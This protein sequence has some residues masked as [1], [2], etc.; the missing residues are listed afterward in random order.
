MPKRTNPFQNLT[1]SIMALFYEPYFN[2]EES[3]LVK[4]EETGSVRELDIL[5]THKEDSAFNILIECRDHQR[6]QDVTWIDQLQGK[7]ARLGYLNIVAVSSSGFTEPAIL[8][9][10]ARGIETLHLREAETEDW[11][12]WKF[13]LDNLN[14]NEYSDLKI[15]SS[16]IDVP[17][18][19]RNLIPTNIR[20]NQ[21]YIKNLITNQTENFNTFINKLALDN[22]FLKE[23][24][25]Q[26]NKPG[27]HILNKLIDF[28]D[29]QI[30]FGH[31][32]LQ[33]TVRK[34]PLTT[35]LLKIQI[36]HTIKNIELKPYKIGNERILSGTYMRDQQEVKLILHEKGNQLEILE[37]CVMEEDTN[38]QQPPSTMDL[39][40]TTVGND[41]QERKVYLPKLFHHY[42]THKKKS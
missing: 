40:V 4:N 32:L 33:Q 24:S 41:G 10:Q 13:G 22:E 20:K 9:A 18:N 2:V 17:E 34:L 35:I 36:N 14:I 37:E 25:E 28:K 1:T 21:A 38:R 7:G 23:S 12:S 16:S 42:S 6:K 29:H 19:F 39:E 3:V 15:L 27:L 8:E 31:P 26:I 30:I 11:G 5:I